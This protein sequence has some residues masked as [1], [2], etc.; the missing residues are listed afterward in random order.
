MTTA[1]QR[2]RLSSGEPTL[3]AM[4]GG[5]F[6][7]GTTTLISGAPGTGKTTLGTQFLC[8]GAAAGQPGVLITFEEFPAALIR[9]S[10]Q[11][12]W[13]LEKLQSE[14]LLQLIFTSPEVF[15]N[16]LKSPDSPLSDTM[17]LMAP[18]RAVLDSATHFR[19]ITEDPIELREIY[20]TLVNALKREGLT[21]LLLDEDANIAK[22]KDGKMPPLPFVVDSVFLM[23]YVEVDSAIRRAIT[24]LKMRGSQHNKDIRAY[25]IGPG[26]LK[27]QE[28]FKDIQG[29]LSGFSHR[30]R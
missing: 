27:L 26:G 7:E 24:I 2:Q 22:P 9:D 30:V 18:K 21:T 20:N 13:D 29:I 5:G 11:L 28:P 25:D 3:D 17:R 14:G 12:G 15:L 23:R 4:M 19:R 1:Q 10:K 8:A 6:L 16:S